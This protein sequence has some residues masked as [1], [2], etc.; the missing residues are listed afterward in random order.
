VASSGNA[1]ASRSIA[2]SERHRLLA[3]G[4][5]VAVAVSGGSD[6]V[7]LLLLLTELAESLGLQL[8]VAHFD[9]RWR[10][11][12]AAD[13]AWVAALAQKL[14]LPFCLGRAPDAPP[15]GNREQ[16]ARRL[17]YAFLHSLLASGD[18]TRIATGHTAD[19]QAETVLLRL[20]RGAGATGL[21][22]ILPAR[23]GTTVVRPLLF[24]RRQELRHW[25]QA[26]RQAWREDPSNVALDRRRNLLRHRFLPELEAAFNPALVERLGTVAELA[27]AEEEFWAAYLVPLRDRFFQPT[28]QGSRASRADL[29]AL[30]LAVRRRLLRAAIARLKGDLRQVD[31]AGIEALVV[32][33]GQSPRHPR[34]FTVAG[35]ACRLSS[36]WLDL[37]LQLRL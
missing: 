5:R 25:L 19:D 32:G 22:G 31:F 18:A 36:Q 13:A 14:A 16:V 20:L 30:P 28:P 24:A 7:A 15:P 23:D 34:L 4:D 1:L 9:H 27:R 35:V 37:A 11:E 26:R 17:R 3:P 10:P 8:C 29:Q 6:S 33:L 2:W 12:S 21:A